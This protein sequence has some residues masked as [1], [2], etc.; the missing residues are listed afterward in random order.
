MEKEHKFA[1]KLKRNF[2]QFHNKIIKILLNFYLNYVTQSCRMV[3]VS[4]REW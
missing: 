3:D 1:Q 4:G 2:S